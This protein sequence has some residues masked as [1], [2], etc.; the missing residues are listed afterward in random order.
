VP[1][2]FV[3]VLISRFERR[4]HRVLSRAE[5]ESFAQ[6]VAR[7]AP[8]RVWI[9][10]ELSASGR[11]YTSPSAVDAVLNESDASFQLGLEEL[12]RREA[13]LAIV[14]D[15][16]AWQRYTASLI[17]PLLLSCRENELSL[18]DALTWLDRVS[19]ACLRSTRMS[20]LGTFAYLALR[21]PRSGLQTR[22]PQ[23]PK[24]VRTGTADLVLTLKNQS[25]TARV[26]P[27][28]Q[29]RKRHDPSSPLIDE[30]LRVLTVLEF[31]APSYPP[32][33]ATIA[34]WVRARRKE[35]DEPPSTERPT[36]RRGKS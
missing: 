29:N 20:L 1:L 17:K 6:S 21:T 7:D 8:E 16:N 15:A 27:G 33:P 18:E 36:V 30:A 24:C 23:Y 5:A 12:R 2:Y 3:G 31:F 10:G 4:Y 28:S 14:G 25:P 11:A 19:I 34:D 9:E 26:T 35:T 22:R 32:S 13:A